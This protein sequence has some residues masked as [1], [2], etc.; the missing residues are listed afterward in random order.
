[1]E[2]ENNYMLRASELM[3]EGLE[4]NVISKII[5]DEYNIRLSPIIIK[6]KIRNNYLENKQGEELI[7]KSEKEESN[8]LK[9]IISR[10]EDINFIEVTR[11][12]FK[13]RNINFK[14]GNNQLDN[15]VRAVV[16]DNIITKAEEVFLKQKA[17][18]FGVDKNI[19]E[20]TKQSLFTN[21]PYLD[22]IIHLIFEDGIVTSEELNYLK[23]KGKENEFA[24]KFI[25]KRFWI[26]GM[27]N[28]LKSLINLNNFKKIII[29]LV[30]LKELEGDEF[31]DDEW[32]FSWLNIFVGNSFETIIDVS[33]KKLEFEVIES[34][35]KDE[36]VDLSEFLTDI[37]SKVNLEISDK[38][39]MPDS[40][41]ENMS[42]IRVKQILNQ[43]KI[44]I[45]SPDVN[46]LIENFNYRI[47]NKLWD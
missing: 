14:T 9:N 46:L 20:I 27:S 26:I 1:M 11:T 29:L 42:L 2:G 44:R 8:K 40:V 7:F 21:N 28:Y 25:N 36:N 33:I 15:I 6:N 19:I 4:D 5:H 39:T 22:D 18:E 43:E 34:A 3:K 31:I 35:S 41:E 47:E 17:I 45:G 13:S 38:K 32:L 10:I 12:I 24:V 16:K 37:Y 30:L 23:E